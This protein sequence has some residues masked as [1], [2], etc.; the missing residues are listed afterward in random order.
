MQNKPYL[1]VWQTAKPYGQPFD[2]FKAFTDGGDNHKDAREF[3]LQIIE[4]ESTYSAHIVEVIESTDYT[5]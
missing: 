1:V 2:S 4:E 3:Y 5:V